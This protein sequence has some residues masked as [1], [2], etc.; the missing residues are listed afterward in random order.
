M[1]RQ[2][3]CQ[4]PPKFR[5]CADAYDKICDIVGKIIADNPDGTYA[6]YYGKDMSKEDCKAKK[7]LIFPREEV[8]DVVVPVT[9]NMM[10]EWY[11]TYGGGASPPCPG[12]RVQSQ[13][14][15]VCKF[16]R[17]R[18]RLY[19]NEI[20]QLNMADAF[21]KIFQ[22]LQDLRTSAPLQTQ[23]FSKNRFLKK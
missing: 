15:I 18:S 5:S 19:Q 7:K 22:V 21:D 14:A 16:W 13:L 8:E 1:A 9:N 6:E 20:V 11:V 10:C 4:P 23:H 2:P 17:A 12:E 3:Q